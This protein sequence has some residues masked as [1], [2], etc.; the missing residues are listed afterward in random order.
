MSLVKLNQND[1]VDPNETAASSGSTLFAKIYVLDCRD[2]IGNT[3]IFLMWF[4]YYRIR[5]N[6][7]TVR[8]SFFLNYWNEM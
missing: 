6:Y 4:S 8:L 1:S 3:Y 5:P 2:D 7:R